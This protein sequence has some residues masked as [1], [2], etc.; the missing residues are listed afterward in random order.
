MNSHELV[1]VGDTLF[2]SS[3]NDDARGVPAHRIHGANHGQ[4]VRSATFT[5]HAVPILLR[6]QECRGLAELS[7]GRLRGRGGK[8][9]GN[10][11]PGCA[12]GTP[13]QGQDKGKQLTAAD[14]AACG[15][16][17]PTHR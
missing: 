1:I 5:C 8:E 12:A 10:V 13:G 16:V 14:E 4:V 7:A 3:T 15:S 6:E 2:E 9:P 11:M 17:L